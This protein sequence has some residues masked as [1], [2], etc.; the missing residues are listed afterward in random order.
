MAVNERFKDRF[1]TYSI[2]TRKCLGYV[3][4]VVT[5]SMEE[6]TGKEID[7]E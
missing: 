2:T 7:L 4:T 1:K 6:E 5:V 3:L